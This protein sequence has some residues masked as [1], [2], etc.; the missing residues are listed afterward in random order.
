MTMLHKPEEVPSGSCSLGGNMTLGKLG[1]GLAC[2]L[3]LRMGVIEAC[4]IVRHRLVRA[5]PET[6]AVMWSQLSASS[7]GSFLTSHKWACA[8]PALSSPSPAKLCTKFQSS[9]LQSSR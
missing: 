1:R 2:W 5:C 8:V 7:R 6:P 4:S 3:T 9:R